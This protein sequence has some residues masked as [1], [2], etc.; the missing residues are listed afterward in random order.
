MLALG[1]EQRAGGLPAAGLAVAC[2]PQPHC[3]WP[4][5]AWPPSISLVAISYKRPVCHGLQASRQETSAIASIACVT[6]RALS[7]AWPP[8]PPPMPPPSRRRRRT[9]APSFSNCHQ[10]WLAVVAIVPI[11]VESGAISRRNDLHPKTMRPN[12]IMHDRRARRP[13]HRRRLRHPR[14]IPHN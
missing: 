1:A 14:A 5:R 8:S 6:E 12:V 11:G 3:A 2:P 10:L 9:L 13:R 7:S 4:Q